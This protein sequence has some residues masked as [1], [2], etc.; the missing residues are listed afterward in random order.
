M[1]INTIFYNEKIIKIDIVSQFK[2]K[3][4][5]EIEKRGYLLWTKDKSCNN[6]IWFQ[7][8]ELENKKIFKEKILSK[9]KKT[10]DYV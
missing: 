9:E 4:R 10:W 1:R 5:Y 3:L 8:V 7:I 2:R 6:T